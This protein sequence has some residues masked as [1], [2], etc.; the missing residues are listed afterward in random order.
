MPAPAEG[1]KHYLITMYLGRNAHLHAY[2]MT[3]DIHVLPA[4]AEEMIQIAE[5][6]GPVLMPVVLMTELDTGAEMVRDVVCRLSAEAAES[7]RVATNFH[8][9][10]F[11]LR[12][13]HP[14]DPRLMELH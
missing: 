11:A 13:D 7:M 9:S 3:D 1:V 6:Y 12:D 10:T 4:V 14:D 5:Q 2:V 8:R